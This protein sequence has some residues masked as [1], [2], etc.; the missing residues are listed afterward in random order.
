MRI[1]TIIGARPQF[2]K[3]AIVSYAIRQ[4]NAQSSIQIE[5]RILHT[6]QHY[7]YNMSQVFF[8][9]MQIPAPT[10]HLACNDQTVEQMRDAIVPIIDQHADYILLYGDTNSTLAGALAAAQCN[11]PIIH[12]EAGLR[13]FNPQMAE[14]HNRIETDKRSTLLFCPTY[15]AVA[16]LR[17][18]GITKGVYMVGDVM[19]DASLLFTEQASKTSDILSRLNLT[20]RQYILATIHRAETTCDV[21]KV[22]NILRAFAQIPYPVILPLHPRTRKVVAASEV[23]T[24]LAHAD[25][26]HIVESVSYVDMQWLEEQA[27]C[28]LTDSGGVQKEAYFHRVPCITMREE[29]EWVE[30]IETGWNTLVG[31]DTQKIVSAFQNL[32]IPST[33]ITEYGDGKASTKIIEILCQNAC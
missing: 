29:T 26:I 4:H 6:G 16:N 28:I 5:E 22:A 11:I 12:I 10:W 33:I 18:E 3:A 19:Y 31:A 24:D 9:Q 8:D 1:I 32:S 14:E 30:T 21:E 17:R 25:N 23:L 15:T 2:I 13:S 27:L 7:D 20:P